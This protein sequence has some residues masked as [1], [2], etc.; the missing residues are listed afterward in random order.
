VDTARDQGSYSV[1]SGSEIEIVGSAAYPFS[2]L[3][4]N[5]DY[6]VVFV[7]SRIDGRRARVSF[8][9]THNLFPDYELIVNDVLAWKYVTLDS[10]PTIVN[11]NRSTDFSGSVDVTF[12][13]GGE[14]ET[15]VG[16]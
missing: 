11:L 5:I 4:P 15:H 10:G 6:R 14:S 12:G 13:S 9:G 2:R 1:Q 7:F 8:H 3:A 16:H